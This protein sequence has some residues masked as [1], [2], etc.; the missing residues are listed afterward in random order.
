[1]KSH[2]YQPAEAGELQRQSGRC[3]VYSQPAVHHSQAR[4]PSQVAEWQE[5]GGAWEPG[6]GNVKF[7]QII[8]TADQ[9]ILKCGRTPT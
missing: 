2:T 3:G 7:A 8:S 4:E 5:Q 6:S 1:M 9:H